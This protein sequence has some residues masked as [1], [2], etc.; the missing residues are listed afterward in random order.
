MGKATDMEYTIPLRLDRLKTVSKNKTDS[1]DKKT[2]N[3]TFD[4]TVV[5]EQ[6]D[7]NGLL[8][9]IDG[10]AA[11]ISDYVVTTIRNRC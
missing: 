7:K 11:N 4:A 9:S 1:E 8:V 3:N 6:K 2:D 5:G 10:T